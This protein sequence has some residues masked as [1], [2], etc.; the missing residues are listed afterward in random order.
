VK[1]GNGGKSEPIY[2]WAQHA[3]EEEDQI[4]QEKKKVNG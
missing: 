2:N 4:D 1:E 3:R